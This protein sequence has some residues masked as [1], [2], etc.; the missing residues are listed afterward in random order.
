[1]N[2]ALAGCLP[3][4]NPSPHR[5]GEWLAPLLVASSPLHPIPS[6]L[7]SPPCALL[8]SLL[9]RRWTIRSPSRPLCPPISWWSSV[10]LKLASR[11]R[12]SSIWGYSSRPE[13]WIR[14]VVLSSEST[15]IRSVFDVFCTPAPVLPR[16]KLNGFYL[17]PG[18]DWMDSE[19]RLLGP[20]IKESL[21]FAVKIYNNTRQLKVN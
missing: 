4:P 12:Y 11:P 10:H 14:D 20:E 2:D 16:K 7:L 17:N 21:A 6:P 18:I 9:S 3:H 1:M 13:P 8:V 5:G 15:C 19:Y